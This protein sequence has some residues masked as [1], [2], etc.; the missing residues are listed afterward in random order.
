MSPHRTLSVLICLLVLAIVIALSACGSA[1]AQTI[2]VHTVTVH[3]EKD[4]NGANPGIYYIGKS[5]F[6]TG[7]YFNSVRHMTAYAG[8][9]WETENR[10]WA[11]SASLAT[12]YEHHNSDVGGW[13]LTPMFSPSYRKEFSLVNVRVSLPC[14]KGVHLSLEKDL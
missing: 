12:G 13:R 2:G 7:A 5:G 1:Q 14:L 9:T 3:Y 4:M 6:T 8:W 10:T 11:M